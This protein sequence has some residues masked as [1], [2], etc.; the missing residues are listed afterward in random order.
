M[1]FRLPKYHS[2]DFTKDQFVAAPNVIIEKVTIKGVAPE[3]YHATSIY[4]EYFK[5][6]GK[7]ILASESRMDCV[8]V[9]KNDKSLEVKEFRNL[10]I[11]DSVI[12]GRNENAESGIYVHVGGF[13]YNESEEQQS[14]VFRTGRTRESSYSKDYDSLY[15]LLKHEREHGYILWVLG[16]AVIFDHDSKNAMAGLI[17]AGFVDVIFAGN[18]LATH[19]LEGSILR[20]ALGQNIYTQQSVFNGHYNHIDII[21]KA[22]RAGS[23]EKFVEQENIKDGVVYSCIK[24]NIPLYLLVP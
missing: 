10:D 20:T 5:V 9:L 6:D 14:F 16:P 18:A 15:E 24:N 7:W 17:D 3:N 8:V 4:P 23:L 19:D 12:L 13:T 1:N 2:P 22:R 11:G 21:N